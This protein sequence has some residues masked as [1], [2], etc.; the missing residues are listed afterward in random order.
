M[1]ALL[2]ALVL[3][4]S[5]DPLAAGQAAY[6]EGRYA[7]AV[8]AL[9]GPLAS[10]PSYEGLVTLGLA[11]GRLERLP[12][13]R[14]AFDRAI[15]LEPGRPEALVERGGLSFLEQHYDAA[16]KDLSRALELGPDDYT[17]DLLAASLQLAGRSEEAL[18]QWNRL[19]R[20][21]LGTLKITGLQ[22][23]R[24]S[25]ARRELS[26]Q[27][28][29]LLDLDRLRESRLR[30]RQVGVF[31]RVTLRP[32]P[33]GNGVADLE[34]ALAER[35]GLYRSRLG[36]L[37]GSGVQ[38]L[39]GRVR[40]EYANLGGSGAS[41]GGQYRWQENRPEGS[42]ALSW[43]RPLGLAAYVSLSASR[44]RQAYEVEGDAFVRR[45]RGLELEARHVLG[46]R[47]LGRLALRV[48]DRSFSE[49][50]PDAPPGVLSGLEV[51]LDRDLV[52]ARRQRLDLSLGFFQSA[53]A[54]GSVVTYPRGVAILASRTHLS[55]PDG[56]AL[57]PSVL[58]ARLLWARGGENMPIDDMF[59][60]GG[61]PDM[62]L[63][64]RAHR[65][66]PE[67]ILGPTPLGRSLV[68]GNLEWRKRVLDR[69]PV[70]AAVVAFVDAARVADGPQPGV[71]SLVDVGVGFHLSLVGSGI[72]RFDYGHG[73]RDGRNAF[74]VGLG[75]V[76]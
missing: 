23:T 22:H 43:P 34:V 45:Y 29:Q 61:G 51:G 42:L 28:G 62:E 48:R 46:A 72:L 56:S 13:A 3:A 25:V 20:P 11:Y 33:L 15:A 40:L 12:E 37:V 68:L 75:E 6:D 58:A 2:L 26:L 35:H 69:S 9:A 39:Q 64:L 1:I 10:A 53:T 57:E 67:G 24:D 31:D 60:P 65:Q 16:V 27:E 21:T 63:P 41:F 66:T 74:F 55:P 71:T 19:G 52:D 18:A 70:Q 7:D 30:L 5:Q 14:A 38:A 44:G 54:L 4:G 50:R 73:L 76:F 49:P 59:A 47:T 36:F 32:L 8:A 17:R